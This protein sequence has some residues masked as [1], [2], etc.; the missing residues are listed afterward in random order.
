VSTTPRRARRSRH[1]LRL[2]TF[3]QAQAAV[4]YI[5]SIVRSL[6]EH[7]LNIQSLRRRLAVLD[8]KP[9]RPDRSILISM[10]EARRDLV[11]TEEEHGTALE[12]LTDLDIQPLDISR[13]LALV[14]FVHDEQLA[15][16]IFDVFDSEPIRSWR[17]QTDPDETR[18]KLTAAQKS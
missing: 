12:E 1:S 4:P 10:E 8:A 13:G 2:W 18:R 14:P 16:Y 3:D 6:R 11:R 5:A 9:G 17:Y 7:A 15:W